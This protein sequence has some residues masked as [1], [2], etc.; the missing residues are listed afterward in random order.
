MFLM[1]VIIRT[2]IRAGDIVE[3]KELSTLV[4]VSSETQR[5]KT[6]S[7]LASLSL[8]LRGKDKV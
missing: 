4:E 1:S 7:V 3:M 5:N 2:A 6:D 8:E